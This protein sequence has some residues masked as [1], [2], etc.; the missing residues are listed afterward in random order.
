MPKKKPAVEQYFEIKGIGLQAN[1]ELKEKMW[2]VETTAGYI[3]TGHDAIYIGKILKISTMKYR[4]MSDMKTVDF[5]A[6]SVNWIDNVCKEI[7]SYHEAVVL[8]D[9]DGKVRILNP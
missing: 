1:P 5:L 3:A 9:T 8:C 2:L 7:L 4:A 6:I